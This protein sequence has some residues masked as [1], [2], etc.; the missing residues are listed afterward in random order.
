M[1][2]GYRLTKREE[3]SVQH[4]LEHARIRGNKADQWMYA[5]MLELNAKA[6]M[7]DERKGRWER[8]R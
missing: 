5:K 6:Q 1:G 3:M 4:A 8:V 2:P 7:R